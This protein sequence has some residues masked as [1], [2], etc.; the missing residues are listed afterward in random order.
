MII[1]YKVRNVLSFRCLQEFSM[2]ASKDNPDDSRYFIAGGCN[3]LNLS[4]IFGANG[5]GKSNLIKS[6]SIMK[7]IVT[8][9]LY[10]YLQQPYYKIQDKNNMEDSYF[11]MILC[12]DNVVYSFG[13]EVD[14][15]NHRL[16]S[17]WLHEY[18]K[19]INDFTCIYEINYKRK[20]VTS[21][22][23]INS[24]LDLWDDK[25][26]KLT[27]FNNDVVKSIYSWFNNLTIYSNDTEDICIPYTESINTMID[28]LIIALKYF[29]TGVVS[30][31]TRLIT[32]ELFDILS[33][34]ININNNS[35]QLLK[36]R[37]NFLLV[38]QLESTTNYYVLEFYHDVEEKYPFQ[39][40]DESDGFIRIV[41]LSLLL[42]NQNEDKIYIIDELD[43]RLHPSLINA[44]I[45]K[46]QEL[47]KDNTT[48]LIIS[49]HASS[50]LLDNILRRDEIWFAN[51]ENNESKIYSLL[52]FKVNFSDKLLKAYFDGRFGG[53]PKISEY[54]WDK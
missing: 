9:T 18:N 22:I 23:D 48:Q 44:F 3:V 12:I 2:I 46:F 40:S 10:E 31:K 11:E 49:T 38:E 20:E 35:N 34:D 25:R 21:N 52:S 53:I 8:K 39:L 5:S 7:L 41:N 37:D 51:K 29:D 27:M 1:N 32:K 6:I 26:L 15:I 50:L 47:T 54:W 36:T 43:R 30:I 16:T 19:E 45:K 42:I 13:F 33:K 4:C 28:N 17:E 24:C 14:F